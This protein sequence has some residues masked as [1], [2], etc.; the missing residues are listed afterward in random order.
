MT[1]ST[2]DHMDWPDGHEA[3][4]DPTGQGN[5][6]RTVTSIGQLAGSSR[7]PGSRVIA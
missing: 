5:R 1:G 3:W 6:V 4:A 7:A 2:G